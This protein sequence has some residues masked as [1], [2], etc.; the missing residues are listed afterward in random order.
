MIL[1]GSKGKIKVQRQVVAWQRFGM[2]L[3]LTQ[4][5][6]K[7]CHDYQQIWHYLGQNIFDEHNNL[8]FQTFRVPYIKFY[9][10]KQV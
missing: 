9:Q 4:H 8:Y 7:C 1:F 6:R 2:V 5:N 10:M 3:I